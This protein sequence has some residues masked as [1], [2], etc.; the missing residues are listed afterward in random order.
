[1]H[2]VVNQVAAV[3][4]D[5]RRSD[6]EKRGV[7]LS[8]VLAAIFLTG[9]KLVVGI[10]TGSLGILS[11]AAHS[12][13]DLVAAAATLF[14][15]RLSGRPPDTRLTYGYGK[16]ENLS[17]LFET[18]LLL[19]TC[20]WIIC[21]AIRRMF[22]KHVEVEP[23]TWAFLV[24]AISIVVDYWRSRALGRVAKKYESQAL[25]AD[26]LHFS[27]DIWSSSVV[28]VGLFLVL[29]SR[30]L[31]VGWLAEADTVAAIGV[32]GIVIYIS[33]RLGRRTVADLLDAIPPGLRDDVSRAVQLVPGVI[34]VQRVRIRRSGPG[35]FADVSLAVSRDT[36][37]EVAHG[38]AS[39][40]ES[41]VREVL[42]GNHDVVVNVLP[43]ASNDEGV[44]SN[45]RLLAA[46]H[47]LGA[48]GIRIYD[49]LGQRLLELHLE[50]KDSLTV[51]EAHAQ[52]TAF[53]ED[54]RQN[55]P[56][57]SRIVTHIEPAGETAA[58]KKA[59][60]ADEARLM[61]VINSLAE[62]IGMSGAPHDVVV[63]RVAGDLSVSFH[64]SLDGALG[65]ADAHELTEK[66]ERG[67]RARLPNLGR[68]VI[69]VEPPEP[70][71]EGS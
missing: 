61:V 33:V 28:I 9:M 1:M 32:A 10:L 4:V 25:Q 17:A 18:V 44:L 36:A 40:A 35:F 24:M 6:S 3:D 47:G 54:V 5:R 55:L 66:L 63:N 21:E 12:G 68:V 37:F 15:V 2:S 23:N 45:V 64:C 53:E 34:D 65:V 71:Q 22:F 29:L 48:H 8:S 52:A 60:P 49:V 13:L 7:A 27:T 42:A 16:V 67:M 50:V 11:E 62:E 19:A 38:I 56:G 70:A 20:V 69:H 59:R 57:I 26:A 51:E 46:R 43:V 58:T 14:A 31:R 39:Q 30:Q 41:A